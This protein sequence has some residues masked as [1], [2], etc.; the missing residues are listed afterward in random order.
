MFFLESFDPVHLFSLQLIFPGIKHP[1]GSSE[2]V[3]YCV[4]LRLLSQEL[5]RW[6]GLFI[7]SVHVNK[8]FRTVQKVLSGR[9]R[10]GIDIQF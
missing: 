9:N 10:Y 5:E 1:A 8:N 6:D 7:P 2:S 3:F 4:F